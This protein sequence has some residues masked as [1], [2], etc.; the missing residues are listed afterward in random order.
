MMLK[1]R[2]KVYLSHYIRGPEG[3]KA[4]KKTIDT[5]I[6]KTKAVCQ[7]LRIRFGSNL[8]LYVPAEMDEFPRIALELDFLNVEQVLDIDCV[9]VSR[10]DALILLDF[11]Q[12]LS[13]GMKRE[14]NTAIICGLPIYSLDGMDEVN[15]E[16]LRVW[17]ETL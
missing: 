11:E 1:K 2:I 12:C 9:I 7:Q 10:C 17:L 6:A 5:N 14:K 13:E 16:L 3:D 15:L 8:D 4:S